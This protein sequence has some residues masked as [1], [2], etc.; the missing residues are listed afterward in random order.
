MRLRSILRKRRSGRGCGRN[1][2]RQLWPNE[3]FVRVG[4]FSLE[5]ARVLEC[6]S[7]KM[8]HWLESWMRDIRPSGLAGGE[9]GINQFALPRSLPCC[10]RV[11]WI[12]MRPFT[13][14]TL[15]LTLRSR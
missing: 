1:R 15:R 11:R 7:M 6:Q 14:N 12:S 2:D 10:P 9:V 5:D 4:I 13:L 3:F 8:A